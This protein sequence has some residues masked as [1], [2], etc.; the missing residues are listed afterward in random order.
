VPART[1]I[2]QAGAFA[3][4]D[5]AAAR[6]DEAR[7]GW[8]GSDTEHIRHR[9]ETV[10]SH[11]AVGGAWLDVALPPG[12]RI[13]LTLRVRTR[14]RTPAYRTPWLDPTNQG[15]QSSNDTSR[16]TPDRKDG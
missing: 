9:P 12:T 8:T 13:T 2:V 10:T 1:V 3:E 6:F 15:G 4:H 11:C 14:V 16:T 5:I 7:P